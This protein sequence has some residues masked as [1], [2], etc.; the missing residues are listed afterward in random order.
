MKNIN[1]R[2]IYPNVEDDCIIAVED[3]IAELFEMT[4]RAERS[5]LRTLYRNRA[6][7]SLNQ[8]DGI[9]HDAIFVAMSPFEIYERKAT[10]EE[11]N[12]AIATLPELQAKRLYAHYFLD[13]SKSDIAKAEGVSTKAVCRSITYGLKSLEKILKEYPL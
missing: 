4:R 7:Y 2:E 12:A 13:M 3:E 11:L 8:N 10:F 9:E 1:L 5:Y 6:H